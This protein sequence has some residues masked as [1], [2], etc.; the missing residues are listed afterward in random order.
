M[1]ACAHELKCLT[2]VSGSFT[3]PLRRFTTNFNISGIPCLSCGIQNPQIMS[4]KVKSLLYFAAFMASVFIYAAL[5]SDKVQE[6]AEQPVKLS[7]AVTDNGDLHTDADTAFFE[8]G[9]LKK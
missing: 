1:M 9:L 7:K 6:M 3:Y 2:T 8:D 4:Y 5:D